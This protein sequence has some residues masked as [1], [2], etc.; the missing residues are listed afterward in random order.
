MLK[1]SCP[2]LCPFESLL[3]PIYWLGLRVFLA[4]I[5][6]QSGWL[7][8]QDMVLAKNLFGKDFNLPESLTLVFSVYTYAYLETIGAVLLAVGL[9]TRFIS[10]LLI[11]LSVFSQFYGVDLPDHYFWMFAFAALVIYGPGKISLDFIIWE[12]YGCKNVLKK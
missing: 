9:F 11:G 10:I 2:V 12:K 8:F 6:W 3:K 7:K 1:K 4:N 5:F